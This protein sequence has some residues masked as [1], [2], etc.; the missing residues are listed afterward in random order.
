MTI[1]TVF[2]DKKSCLSKIAEAISLE[3]EGLKEASIISDKLISTLTPLMPAAG[4][5]APQIGISKQVFI[6]SWD[7][8]IANIETVINP[9]IIQFNP[10]LQASWEACF[11]AMQDNNVSQA[12]FLSRAPRILVEYYNLKGEI[13][14]RELEGFAAKV[15]QHEYDHLKGI[16]CVNK[17]GS[18]IKTF[19]SEAELTDFMMSI[20]QKEKTSYLKP[21]APKCRL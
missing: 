20:K 16:V 10:P 15:F 11:S 17:E 6:F 7:R 9:K 1:L 5:A 19:S 4:L 14:Q 8:S 21:T 3:A 2:N 18:E 13:I 12:A